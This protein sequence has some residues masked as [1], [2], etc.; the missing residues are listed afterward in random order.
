MPI[1]PN[2]SQSDGRSQDKVEL[3]KAL[4]YDPNPLIDNEESTAI[5]VP[6]SR[7]KSINSQMQEQNLKAMESQLRRDEEV[8]DYTWKLRKYFA[9]GMTI[10]VALW[11]I[12]LIIVI[13]LQGFGSFHLSDNLLIAIFTTTTANVFGFLYIILR[14]VFPVMNRK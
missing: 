12:Q 2:D 6:K 9:I 3:P 11:T 8:H 5:K 1:N 10:L 14:F 13:F 7:S 4:Q